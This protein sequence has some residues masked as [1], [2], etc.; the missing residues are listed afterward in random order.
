MEALS[1]SQKM[2][3]VNWIRDKV[4]CTSVP[5]MRLLFMLMMRPVHDREALNLLARV[6]VLAC[7]CMSDM[8]SSRVSRSY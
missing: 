4:A 3:T 7:T 2:P 5:I 8:S 1:C 6:F